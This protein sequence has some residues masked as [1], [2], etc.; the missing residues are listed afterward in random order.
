VT[1]GPDPSAAIAL[2]LA[3][4]YRSIEG[5]SIVSVENSYIRTGE[6]PV[7][8]EDGS[9]AMELHGTLTRPPA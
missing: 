8:H 3:D 1:F 9:F 5:A 2:I 4:A 6:L 7:V